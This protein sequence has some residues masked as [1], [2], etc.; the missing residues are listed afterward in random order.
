MTDEKKYILYA[1]RY[2]GLIHPILPTIHYNW[3]LFDDVF[4]ERVKDLTKKCNVLATEHSV[5]HRN[6]P[7]YIRNIDDRREAEQKKK[8]KI[9]EGIDLEIKDKLEKQLNLEITI[10]IQQLFIKTYPKAARYFINN[11]LDD[12]TF[13]SPYRN[14]DTLLEIQY[15][16]KKKYFLDTINK[17]LYIKTESL[18]DDPEHPETKENPNNYM[19]DII[20]THKYYMNILETGDYSRKWW[21]DLSKNYNFNDKATMD[22]N[23]ITIDERNISWANAIRKKILSRHNTKIFLIS[24]GLAHIL[25]SPITGDN[26]IKNLARDFEIIKINI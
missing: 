18:D 8:L 14:L 6:Q 20:K 12:K 21:Q 22:Y 9:N 5:L 19:L 15:N 11:T 7:K 16:N 4:L 24:C 2:N 23:Y 3:D 25:D 13:N 26:L 10:E 1:I 17:E